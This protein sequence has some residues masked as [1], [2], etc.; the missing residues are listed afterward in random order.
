MAVQCADFHH[1]LLLQIFA[2]L[3]L[4]GVVHLLL[5]ALLPNQADLHRLKLPAL[6]LRQRLLLLA[7]LVA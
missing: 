4:H 3:K 2:M 5:M 1:K 6:D 7:Q